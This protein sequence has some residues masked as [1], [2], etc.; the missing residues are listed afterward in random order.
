MQINY[1]PAAAGAGE[2]EVSTVTLYTKQSSAHK[3]CLLDIICKMKLNIQYLDKDSRFPSEIQ[4]YKNTAQGLFS[5]QPA[6][7]ISV[8]GI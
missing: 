4:W 7:R 1:L 5:H 6:N 2:T 3:Y 8:G